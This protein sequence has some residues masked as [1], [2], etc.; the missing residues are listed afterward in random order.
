M[1][2]V[3]GGGGVISIFTLWVALEDDPGAFWMVE[4]RSEY[5]WEGDPEGS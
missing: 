4:A 2:Q 3:R 5:E 1:A